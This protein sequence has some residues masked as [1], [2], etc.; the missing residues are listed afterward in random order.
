[1]HREGKCKGENERIKEYT[2]G[3]KKYIERCMLKKFVV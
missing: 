1:M 3:G 2:M